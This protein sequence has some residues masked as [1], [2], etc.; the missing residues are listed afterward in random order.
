MS[1]HKIVRFA[2]LALLFWYSVLSVET[3]AQ[4]TQRCF[5]ETGYCIEGRIRAFWEQNGGLIVFG[6]PITPLRM[7][8]VEGKPVLVQWFER[9]RLEWHP[10]QTPP[11][12]VLLGRLGA[13]H[14]LQNGRDW[15]KFAR[16]GPEQGCRFFDE[17]GHNICG[18]ILT[19]WQSNGLE[20]DGKT[21]TSEQ[22]SLALFGMPLSDL[23]TEIMRDG[24]ERQV[25]W[26]E[27]ARLEI[28]PDHT[29]SFV[30]LPGLLGNEISMQTPP[31]T[32]H[33][34]FV[35]QV[36]AYT[37]VHRSQHGCPELTLD[38]Q[39]MLA[40]QRHTEDMAFNDFVGHTGSN[41]SS[42]GDRIRATGYTFS[43]WAENAAAGYATP[44]DVVNGWMESE[45]HRSN[46]LNC[47]LRDIGV[48]YFYLEDDPGELKF[49]NYWTQVFG[50]R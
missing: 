23:Q 15:Q 29:P 6:L 19:F 49:R 43:T 1:I 5:V 45:G 31:I 42:P 34:E 46:I 40:A 4:S 7:E 38:A 35:N 41:G 28:H 16:R 22:E 2:L 48:G 39:L 32:T 18:N 8:S 36:V 21:G 26:F 44:E 25:Q 11:Y 9:H 37:N 20:F 24:Q 33:T 27:R 50:A 3:H 47:T 12:D 30:V 17:T 14:L 10:D 13:D